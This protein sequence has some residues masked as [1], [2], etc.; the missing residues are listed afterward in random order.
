MKILIVDDHPIYAEGLR[1]LLASWG[2]EDTAVAVN[3][4]E[5]IDLAAALRPD[6]AFMDIGLP[7]MD[8]IAATAEI[9]AVSPETKVVMLTSLGDEESL[10]RAIKAG[11]S[12]YLIKTLSGE[13]LSR[14]LGDLKEGRNPFSAGMEDRLL[15][16]LRRGYQAQPPHNPAPEAPS[17][18]RR[19]LDVIRL[20][21]KGR[22][23]KE[24]GRE[25]FISER[26]VKFHV[27]QAKLA[28]GTKSKESLIA[29]AEEEARK[30]GD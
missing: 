30:R 10:L 3:G 9:R 16:E 22:S 1:N 14:C 29:L 19:Q 20:M 24:I 28:L 23:Y 17:L 15:A 25:L 12:G 6:V 26:T 8:G 13:E 18:T 7:G 27:E 21:A 11:A 4:P 5:A 2:Y